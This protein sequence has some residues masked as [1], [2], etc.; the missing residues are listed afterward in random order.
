MLRIC[1]KFI[2]CE[3]GSALDGVCLK[4]NTHST[5]FFCSGS[6]KFRLMGSHKLQQKNS[7]KLLK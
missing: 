2:T 6:A 4:A 1:M 7:D 3:M 5:D